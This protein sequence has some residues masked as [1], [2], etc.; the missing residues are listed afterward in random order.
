MCDECFGLTL[1]GAP[2]CELCGAE[3]RRGP[4][5]RWPFAI[6]FAAVGLVVCAVGIRAGGRDWVI[7]LGFAAVAIVVIAALIVWT[8][9]NR[10]ESP[11]D[12]RLREANPEPSADLLQR[13]TSP[14]RTRIARVVARAAPLSGRTT[15][16]VLVAA[17]AVTAVAL[18]LG[19]RLPRWVELELVLACWWLTV[20]TLLVTLL[21]K[22]LRLADDHRFT[23]LGYG[24]RAQAPAKNSEKRGWPSPSGCAEAGGCADGFVALLVILLA[25]AAAWLLVEVV[26]PAVFFAVYYFVIKA[27]GRVARDRHDCAGN[28]PRSIVW[29]AVWAS[30]YV[31][32]PAIL[33]W[34]VQAIRSLGH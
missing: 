4:A 8:G 30:V 21:Y 15:A 14:Y 7:E 3:L 33:V 32:P 12:I 16:L 6:V 20:A 28:L 17:F 22:G 18:P 11:P 2:L 9:K 31:L 5:S 25:A 26:F 19:L 10:D 13:A 34:A 29:G 1:D 24:E 27:I 23:L